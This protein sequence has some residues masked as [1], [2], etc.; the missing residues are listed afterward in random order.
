MAEKYCQQ[1][2]KRHKKLEKQPALVNKK[3]PIL[4]HDNTRPDVSKSTLQKLNEIGYETLP[5]PPYSPDLLPIDYHF[6]KHLNHFLHEKCFKNISD[7]KNAFNNFITRMQNFYVNG[8]NALVL[9]WQK[10]VECDGAY[11]D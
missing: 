3:G 2:V 11:F 4:L 10:C 7:I 8:I 9:R 6:F 5:H 1:I